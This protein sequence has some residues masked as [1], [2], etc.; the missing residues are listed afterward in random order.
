MLEGPE[1]MGDNL[2]EPDHP[3]QGREPYMDS[4][5]W[6]FARK[7]VLWFW[8]IGTILYALAGPSRS[9]LWLVAGLLIV[10]LDRLCDI[11]NL[12][13]F[14]MRQQRNAE[15]SSTNAD[16]RTPSVNEERAIETPLEPELPPPVRK[17][18]TKLSNQEN[19]PA[20]A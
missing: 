18:R 9:A 10:I 6:P 1:V 17:P 8:G 11:Y 16:C 19:R 15:H 14:S 2:T 20:G 13:Y 5:V 3:S 12:M 7:L 4:P